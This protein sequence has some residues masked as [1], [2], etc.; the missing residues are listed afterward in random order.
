MFLVFLLSSCCPWIVGVDDKENYKSVSFETFTKHPSLYDGDL[1][2]IEGYHLI[3]V[4]LIYLNKEVYS[5]LNVSGHEPIESDYKNHVGLF[6]NKCIEHPK[7][8]Y[9]ESGQ[10]L[11]YG[12]GKLGKEVEKGSGYGGF[13][14]V[15]HI[16]FL[17]DSISQ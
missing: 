7:M 11:I 2:K 9:M 15:H 8:E 16:E 12:K 14:E 3:G 5:R 1:I 13:I 6:Y 4:S 17:A 10:F